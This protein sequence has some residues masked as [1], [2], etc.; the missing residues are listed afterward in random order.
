[1]NE[2]TV[3]K[4]IKLNQ[5]SYENIAKEFSITRS[6][7][8]P[9][10]KKLATNVRDGQKILD[11]GCGNGRLFEELNNKDIEYFGTDSCKKLIDIARNRYKSFA[12]KAQF[13]VFNICDMPFGE[14][15][16]D[17]I[18]TIAVLNHLPSKELRIRALQ[19]IN[20][21]LSPGGLLL[22]TN[23]NLWQLTIKKKSLFYYTLKKWRTSDK[24]WKE[25]YGLSK[26]EFGLKDIMTEW[27][28][29]KKINPLYYYAFS[30]KELK[31]L[32]KEAGFEI[33]DSYYSKKGQ[34]VNRFKGG[35]IV[36]VARK[37]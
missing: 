12:P 14:K 7:I 20:K 13:G 8:W 2:K 28:T 10:L 27:K 34:K 31:S 36:I 6:Y 9:D 17:V 37:I 22:M 16:F 33:L 3:E 35:N 25:K 21:L 1:M 11:V 23:W 15:Q 4:I 5:E 29:D 30:L 24:A 32:V 18:F 26:K 19:K